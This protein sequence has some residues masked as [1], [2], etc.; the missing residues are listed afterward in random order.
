MQIYVCRHPRII[1]NFQVCVCVFMVELTTV[2]LLLMLHY[3]RYVWVCAGRQEFDLRW[4]GAILSASLHSWVVSEIPKDLYLIGTVNCLPW[5]KVVVAWKWP[6]RVP[7]LR[8]YGT[9]LP[10]LNTS[11]LL[12]ID[13]IRQAISTGT[14]VLLF[15]TIV[16][17]L[18]PA[19]QIP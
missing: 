13:Y 5:R 4:K 15:R 8:M 16:A 17:A 6:H 7:W 18:S 12:S 1:I 9:S 11:L 2:L 10:C 19:R 3:A 14:P